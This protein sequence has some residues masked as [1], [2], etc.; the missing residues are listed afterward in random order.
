MCGS[1]FN[2]KHMFSCRSGSGRILRH[3]LIVE[4]LR[5]FC[6]R[7]GFV[8]RKEVVCVEGRQKRMDLVIYSLEGDIWIDVS[9]VDQLARSHIK[10]PKAC[11]HREQEKHS[12][13]DRF[14]SNRGVK[15]VPFVLNLAGGLG[16]EALEF[17]STLANQALNSDPFTIPNQK[18][19]K[20]VYIEIVLQRLSAVLAHGI[21]ISVDEAKTKA[22]GR[23]WQ[24]SYMSMFKPTIVR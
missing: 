2:A 19:W 10:N 17:L 21:K 20:D 18:R 13:W 11:K 22:R 3:D 5:N 1:Q 8:V 7:A 15:F 14:A 9:V 4:F 6:R 12:K 24:T 23:R 16:E